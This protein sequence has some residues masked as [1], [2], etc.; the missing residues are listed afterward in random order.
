MRLGLGD[1]P[2]FEQTRATVPSTLPTAS[3]PLIT[4]GH[5]T[6]LLY[7]LLILPFLGLLAWT[8]VYFYNVSLDAQMGKSERP[9]FSQLRPM[10]LDDLTPVLRERWE[11]A[12]QPPVDLRL[13]EHKGRMLLCVYS[14]KK[15]VGR[16]SVLPE[17]LDVESILNRYYTETGDRADTVRLRYRRGIPFVLIFSSEDTGETE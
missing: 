16:R 2:V 7:L 6:P 8:G 17:D 10:M 15:P 11:A 12:Y 4:S 13:E 3:R 9:L 5:P 1:E 14:R